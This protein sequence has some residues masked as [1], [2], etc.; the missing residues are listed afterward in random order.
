MS[1]QVKFDEWD[2]IAVEGW[3]MAYGKPKQTVSLRIPSRPPSSFRNTKN[4]YEAAKA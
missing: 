4:T 3:L 1:Y 2:S